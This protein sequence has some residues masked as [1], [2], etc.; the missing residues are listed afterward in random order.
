MG[1]YFVEANTVS[2]S[3]VSLALTQVDDNQTALEVKLE[4]LRQGIRGK[5]KSQQVVLQS[6]KTLL[7]KVN[8][9]VSR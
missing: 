9:I 3:S 6:T 8:N 2:R 5:F 7:D 1:Y 4:R